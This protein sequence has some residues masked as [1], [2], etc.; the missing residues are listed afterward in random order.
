MNC[1]IRDF[2]ATGTLYAL[3][4]DHCPRCPPHR[5]DA[6]VRVSRRAVGGR[7]GNRKERTRASQREGPREEEEVGGEACKDVSHGD[8]AFR[9][10]RLTHSFL[11]VRSADDDSGF[12]VSQAASPVST[13]NLCIVSK[14]DSEAGLA[15]EGEALVLILRAEDAQ[16]VDRL[17]RWSCVN[18]LRRHR[19]RI[20][21]IVVSRRPPFPARGR[22][23]QRLD[24]HSFY[25][26]HRQGI[27]TVR[28]AEGM[29][30]D[31]LRA[32]TASARWH[33]VPLLGR[34]ILGVYTL[35]TTTPSGAKTSSVSVGRQPRGTTKEG[36]EHEKEGAGMIGHRDSTYKPRITALARSHLHLSGDA[37]Y[38]ALFLR[39][40][41]MSDSSHPG[42]CSSPVQGKDRSGARGSYRVLPPSST[43]LSTFPVELGLLHVSC[44]PRCMLGQA[45]GSVLLDERV[46]SSP[47]GLS[48]EDISHDVAVGASSAPS[49][50]PRLTPLPAWKA[51]QQHD[52]IDAR[53][54]GS[55]PF[56]RHCVLATAVRYASTTGL[57]LSV[58]SLRG[59]FVGV[60]VAQCEQRIEGESLEKAL[61]RCRNPS[62]IYARLPGRAAVPAPVHRDARILPLP[63]THIH[64]RV[65]VPFVSPGDASSPGTLALCELQ[66]Q[67]LEG[68]TGGKPAATHRHLGGH[69]TQRSQSPPSS[70]RRHLFLAA[71]SQA[72]SPHER[73]Q[74]L[75]TSHCVLD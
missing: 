17:R 20:T 49:T 8:E 36:E 22:S 32:T 53:L 40:R 64:D 72:H 35:R 27:V 58:V 45:R 6:Q 33:H 44:V 68:Q 4:C 26:R 11:V 41:R 73:G 9:R 69:T 61:P 66:A 23:R 75:C 37:D 55:R 47:L 60:T 38:A 65:R 34:L 1:T 16:H 29:Q 50:S 46:L 21:P 67:G 18:R 3:L 10:C 48:E 43:I 56:L 54:P 25:R 28:V 71:F 7:L 42:I 39:P 24:A 12:A 59:C 70:A 5:E 19:R 15:R 57:G 13:R 52:I 51:P 74:E 2:E 62:I 30:R 63:H 14:I 31:S